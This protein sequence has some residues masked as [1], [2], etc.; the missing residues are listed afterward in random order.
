M[1]FFSHTAK[2]SISGHVQP[3]NSGPLVG[4]MLFDFAADKEHCDNYGKMPCRKA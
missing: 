2:C 4:V 1:N 3:S